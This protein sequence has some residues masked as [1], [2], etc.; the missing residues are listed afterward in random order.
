ME[1]IATLA[2]LPKVEDARQAARESMAGAAAGRNPVADK[3]SAAL[4][5]A[6]NAI[7]VAVDH[8]LSECDRNLKP[9]TA[10]EWRRIF[11]HDVLPRWGGRPVAEIT[12]ADVLELVNDKAARRE[13]KRQDL[14]EGAAVQAGKMLTRLRTFFGWAIAHDLATVDPTAGIRRPAKEAS[15]DRVLTDDEIRAFWAGCEVLGTPFGPLFRLMLLTAQREGEVAGL[16]WSELDHDDHIWTIPSTRTKNGKP[17]IVHLSTLALETIKAIPRISG[18]DLL[19]SGNGRTAVS[20][21]S[22]AKARLDKTILELLRNGVPESDSEFVLEPW[23]L[24]DLRRTA[25]TGMARLNV[26]PHIADKILNHTAGAI[27][28]VAATY[29]RFQYLDDR[30]MALER[31][32]DFVETVVQKLSLKN[33]PISSESY[34]P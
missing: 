5:S 26:P 20:G 7:R 14:T 24:H 10:R 16:R 34:S 30:R 6:G 8:Y 3:R 15:R 25:T 33:P 11:E 32:G 21:F 18:Q 28:G 29:N 2:R 13:R 9:K 27:R 17:H 4:D 22:S 23:V 1:T 12:K 19:F 31:W